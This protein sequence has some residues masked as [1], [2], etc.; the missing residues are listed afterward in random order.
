MEYTEH[1]SFKA[2]WQ[3]FFRLIKHPKEFLQYYLID[4]HLNYNPDPVKFRRDTRRALLVSLVFALL[5]GIYERLWAFSIFNEFFHENIYLHW[6]LWWTMTLIIA[7]LATNRRWDQI[8]LNLLVVLAVED[9][10]FWIV[11]WIVERQFPFPAK[12][13][14]DVVI[15]PFRVLGNWGTATSFWPYIPRF[16]YI[17][18]VILISYFL[19]NRLGGPKYNQ[20]VDW[21]FLPVLLPF[22][23]G[24]ITS[25]LAFVVLLT[26]ISILGYGWGIYLLVLNQKRDKFR[27][28]S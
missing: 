25:D 9:F 18:A 6:G 13:W 20:I 15:T 1:K 28:T 24:F 21:I 10:V 27:D 11:E 4:F 8:I 19:I 16:Y 22:F 2:R 5:F 23:I 7:Y 26:I 17:V 12:N 14:W 3:Q